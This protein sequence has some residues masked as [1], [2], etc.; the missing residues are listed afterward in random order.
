MGRSVEEPETSSEVVGQTEKPEPG[1]EGG[2]GED[3]GEEAEKE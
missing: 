2:C 1:D 3:V